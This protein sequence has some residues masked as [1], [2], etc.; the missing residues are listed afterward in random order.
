MSE[1]QPNAKWQVRMIRPGVPGLDRLADLG[2][3]DLSRLPF[4][5]QP[6]RPADIGG[7]LR[8]VMLARENMLEDVNYRKVV[9]NRFVVE[10]SQENYARQFRPIE[11]QV[12][13]QWRDR[14]LEELV[15]AN[16]R[17]GRKE[18]RFG[19]RLRL[20]VRPAGNLRDSEARV[21][22]RVEPDS[23]RSDPGRGAPARPAG[24]GTLVAPPGAPVS[25]PQQARPRVAPPMH[26]V[27]NPRP[28]EQRAIPPDP[29]QGAPAGAFLELVPTGQR[30]ALR[31]GINT[32]GRSETCQIHLDMPGVQEKRLVSGQHAYIQIERGQSLLFD[33]SPDGR[34]SANGT[35]VNLRRVPPGGYRLQNGDA[36][37]L[38]AADP[39]YPRS[40]T[41]GVA[42]FYFW[43]DRGG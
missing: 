35:Y 2:L 24:P 9:P 41:P 32:I 40:D 4:L 36:I 13:Q 38:A 11:G 23:A 27:T 14:L 31:E 43:T 37:V 16:N 19:G 30:W 25:P 5:N 28:P 1:S 42:T 18:F 6:I 3:P 34:P 20:E 21:L 33:G 7:V 12:L 17:Q 8:D 22:S 10:V 15:T 26:P 29:A 39:L